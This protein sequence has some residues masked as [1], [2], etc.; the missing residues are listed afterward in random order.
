MQSYTTWHMHG[1]P[2]MSDEVHHHYEMVGNEDRD[3]GGI[4]ALVEDQIRG[5]STNTNQGE[6]VK[7]FDRLLNDARSE[8][9]PNCSS[10]T[11]LSF[12]IELLN[13][14]V[15]NHMTN[16][17]VDMWLHFL[18]RLLPEG[19]LVPKSTYETRKILRDLGLSYELI[20]A[21]INDCVLF[22]KENAKLDKCPKCEESR[23]K[24]NRGR[25]KKIPRKV[26]RYL[27]VTPR[28]KNLYMN[29]KRAK[30]MRW[31]KDKRVDDGE[32]RH[33]ADCD[34][35]K[36]FDTQHPEFA[37]EPRNVRLGLAVDGFNPFGN[38]DNSYSIWPIILVPYN[39]P[40]W[41]IM[42]E[43]FLMLSLL[44]PGD[45][46]PGIDIDVYMQPLVD[47]LKELRFANDQFH[48]EGD[49]IDVH[50]AIAT[51]CG[52]RLSDHTHKLY[53]KFKSL[54]ESKGEGYARSHPPPKI[55]M[56]QWTSL[57]EKKW[58][59]KDWMLRSLKNTSN[60]S[61]NKTKHRCGSKSLP[62]R[63]NEYALTHKGELPNLPEFYKS[64]HYNSDK[65][66]WIAPECQTNFEKMKQIEAEHNQ[67]GATPLTQ[68]EL[69]IAALKKRPGYVKGLGLRPSSSFRTTCESATT[70]EYVTRLEKKLEERDETIEKLLEENKQQQVLNASIMEFLIE[71]GYTGHLG[72]GGLS[73]ND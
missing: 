50:K 7:R 10:F 41:L 55:S 21:C 58:T 53:K 39:L 30:D 8:V 15:T 12:V 51:R 66:Q 25:G 34:E 29:K 28:L 3:W 68:E 5:D 22:R 26:L 49:P 60:R 57:I 13:L 17:A 65:D 47:E 20:D 46:Q 6:E 43:P 42:K 19:N 64:T 67:A 33:P 44:I 71:K 37:L 2:Y 36:E 18:R 45:K 70:I 24:I 14:K 1:E 9:Y 61:S 63:V 23:Y 38:M 69:S 73:S 11:L 32:W 72:S 52:R 40:P 56:E 4:D 59:N 62:V 16:K 48:F 27:P 54:K 35:W 31:H